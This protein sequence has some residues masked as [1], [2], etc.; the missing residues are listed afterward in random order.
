MGKVKTDAYEIAAR[1]LTQNCIMKAEFKE[2]SLKFNETV[3]F[4]RSLRARELLLNCAR[5]LNSNIS[6]SIDTGMRRV[7]LST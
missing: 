3:S 6:T 5:H 2:I 4:K 7:F 1:G